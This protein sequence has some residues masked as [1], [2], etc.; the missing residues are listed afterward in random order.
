MRYIRAVLCVLLCL[1]FA[2]AQNQ[3]PSPG[4]P[5]QQIST[6]PQAAPPAA[7]QESKPDA[8]KADAAPQQGAQPQSSTQPGTP[9]APALTGFGLEDG[10]PVKLRLTRNL[11][12][13]TDKKGD[14]VDFEVME[15][16]SVNGLVVIPR[17]GIAWATITEA[18]PKRRMG[19]GGKLDVNIDS[20][21]LKDGEKVPMR[22]VKENKGGGHVGAMTGAM[23]ATGIVF[24]PAA[25]LFLFMHGKDINIPKG[26]EI[27]AYVASNI[28]LEKAKF[29]EG[30]PQSATAAAAAA[31]SSITPAEADAMIAL[32]STPVGAEVSVDD[33]FVGNA[34]AKLRLKPGKHMIK[35]TMV[36]YK[37]WGREMTV[38]SG[39]EVN[40]TATLEKVN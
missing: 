37:D 26:T 24:F 28:P 25:P 17:G 11:S 16:V 39:S 40:L 31:S 23:V 34:P 38:M 27:T 18:Q 35:V 8:P 10:T 29:Q 13:G 30:S 5:D 33:A 19:R 6:Q 7:G 21:R 20:V 32:V 36:G 14:T 1:Q 15:D 22:A 9:A 3:P 4:S 2:I 12:S